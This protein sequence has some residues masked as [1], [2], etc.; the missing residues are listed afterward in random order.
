MQEGCKFLCIGLGV[1]TVGQVGWLF[2]NWNA[3][4]FVVGS[5]A[6]DDWF[7]VVGDGDVIGFGDGD[8]FVG[9]YS[10][11]IIITCLSDGKQGGLDGGDSM[12]LSCCW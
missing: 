1:C 11:A 12:T 6:C 3:P 7:F 4:K 5:V 2:W 10:D 9:E 8:F